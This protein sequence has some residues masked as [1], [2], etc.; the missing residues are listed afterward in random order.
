MKRKIDCRNLP[1]RTTHA[2]KSRTEDEKYHHRWNFSIVVVVL[3]IVFK[4][5][6]S[7]GKEAVASEDL[8]HLTLKGASRHLC[9]DVFVV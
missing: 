9:K 1:H 8:W 2:A 3:V 7:F 4:A 6:R 5:M